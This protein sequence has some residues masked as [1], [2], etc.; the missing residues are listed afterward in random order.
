MSNHLFLPPPR[1][2]DLRIVPALYGAS[3]DIMRG[4]R[5]LGIRYTFGGAY[6]TFIA[7]KNLRRT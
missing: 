6:A 7:H 5:L 1:P 2:N 4:D 3:F